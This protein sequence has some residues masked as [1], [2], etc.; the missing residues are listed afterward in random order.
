[1]VLPT[2]L[3]ALSPGDRLVVGPIVF[4]VQVDGK[5]QEI[6]PVKMKSQAKTTP[7]EVVEHGVADDQDTGL[8]CAGQDLAHAGGRDCS[9]IH[10]RFSQG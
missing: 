7:D 9:V 6:R 3:S 10:V 5:P 8:A 2:H 1:M 4:T